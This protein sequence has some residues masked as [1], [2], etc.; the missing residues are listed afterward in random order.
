MVDDVL[1][2]AQKFG[3]YAAAV[4]I[5][6][7]SWFKA[8]RERAV[9]KV[10]QKLVDKDMSIN[11][12]SPDIKTDDKCDKE[13]LGRVSG[14]TN[15]IDARLISIEHYL[16]G[17]QVVDAKLLKNLTD[18]VQELVK[19]RSSVQ[20]QPHNR[21]AFGG[22]RTTTNSIPEN[23]DM[24]VNMQEYPEDSEATD[25]G[26][27]ERLNRRWRDSSDTDDDL[28]SRGAPT[29]DECNCELCTAISDRVRRNRT[30]SK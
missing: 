21:L 14:A 18:S 12:T 2:I 27:R 10:L 1:D 22:L 4:L 23:V 6:L 15:A 3:P 19:N 20:V 24:D 17:A 13:L 11:F 5:V 8:R 25:N 16:S 7:W 28:P 9:I 26:L 30:A 29:A